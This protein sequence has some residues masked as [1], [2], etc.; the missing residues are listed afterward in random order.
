MKTLS[1]IQIEIARWTL[2]NFPNHS[3]IAPLLGLQEEL[4]EL[5][6]HYLK[7][8]QGIRNN[9]NHKEGIKDAIG[10]LMIYL[11]DFCNEEELNLES[12]IEETWDK[13]KQRDWNKER[14]GD[15]STITK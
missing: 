3:S 1:E 10:D 12:I 5:S 4:G 11:M 13:V 2:M 9:E 7:M 14:L 15:N 6:H 8:M